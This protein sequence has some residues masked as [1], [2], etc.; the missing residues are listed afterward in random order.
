M[1]NAL[2]APQALD[3]LFLE[4]RCRC[5][6]V[7]AALDRVERGDG[8]DMA[9]QD[10]RWNQLQQALQ[11][12]KS[13]SGDRAEQIQMLFSDDYDPDWLSKKSQT[14]RNGKH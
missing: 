2:T 1:S 3:Q 5:L 14:H 4:I 13:G 8:F 6:D 9:R 12:L 11:L 7:G 10:P